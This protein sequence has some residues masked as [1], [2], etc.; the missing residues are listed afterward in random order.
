MDP[1]DFWLAR[2]IC[3]RVGNRAGPRFELPADVPLLHFI[4]LENVFVLF[5]FEKQNLMTSTSQSKNLREKSSL[6]SIT[7]RDTLTFYFEFI[8]V[9]VCSF[10]K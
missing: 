5:I 10:W 4:L 6:H 8:C 2:A 7:L 1:K 3:Y 9:C